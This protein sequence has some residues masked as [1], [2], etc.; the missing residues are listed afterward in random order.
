VWGKRGHSKESVR[1]EK[2]GKRPLEG[3]DFSWGEG[4]ERRTGGTIL[5]TKKGRCKGVVAIV[6]EEKRL[7]K[8][9][10]KTDISTGNSR[11]HAIGRREKLFGEGPSTVKQ[12]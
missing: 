11:A 2:K 5:K 4:G 7:G 9:R 12:R 3:K 6:S 8:G 10:K 1:E